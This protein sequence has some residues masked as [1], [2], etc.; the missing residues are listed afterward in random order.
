M[1]Y[2]FVARLYNI[3]IFCSFLIGNVFGGDFI[4]IRLDSSKNGW[5]YQFIYMQY[6]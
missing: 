3:F 2:M 5:V 6:T 1:N 4:S